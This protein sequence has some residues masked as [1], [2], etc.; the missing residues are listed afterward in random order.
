LAVTCI[1]LAGGKSKRLG[2]NKVV[3]II[4]QQSLIERVISVLSCFK[5][6]I[7]VV[8]AKESVLPELI[9]YPEVKVVEDIFPGKGS[10]GG[11]YTGLVNSKTFSN[12]VVACD[13]PFV[14]PALLKYMFGLTESYDVVI[15]RINDTLE[16]LHAVYSRNCISP[17]EYLIEQ[18]RLS[19]L[20][21]YKMVSVKYIES[22]EVEKLDP[23]HLSFFNINTESD[24]AAGK[25]LAVKEDYKLDKC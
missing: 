16:P 4:G 15:P 20:E 13:M 5:S 12:L 10:L 24:L 22:A 6:E 23:R 2:R 19:I 25:E 11:L 9:K 14:N 1:V 3:E 8:K 21:L 7:I 18:D 17:I